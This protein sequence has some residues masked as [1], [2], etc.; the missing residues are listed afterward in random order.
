MDQRNNTPKQGAFNMTSSDQ[1]ICYHHSGFGG[2][3]HGFNRPYPGRLPLRNSS[4]SV[5]L[6]PLQLM[7]GFEQRSY[8]PA[9]QQTHGSGDT[10]VYHDR[11]FGGVRMTTPAPPSRRPSEMTGI[12]PT[13]AVESVDQICA[14]D[15]KIG[16]GPNV[17][18]PNLTREALDL[19]QRPY[20]RVAIDGL[21]NSDRFQNTF[22]SHF[23]AQNN[24][25]SYQPSIPPAI[26]DFQMRDSTLSPTLSTTTTNPSST[27]RD[28]SHPTFSAIEQRCFLLNTLYHICVDATAVYSRS[29]LPARHSRSR[30]RRYHPYR[31]TYP[32]HSSGN[33]AAGNASRNSA[34]PSLMDNISTICTHLWRKA[35][36][37][38]MAPHRAEADAVREMR[39]LYAWAE[40]VA[41][42]MDSDGLLSVDD[43]STDGGSVSEYGPGGGAGFNGS[44]GVEVPI[45]VGRAAKRICEWVGDEEGWDSCDS[46]CNEL[47]ELGEKD[48]DGDRRMN[49]DTRGR[50][51]EEVDDGEIV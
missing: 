8:S 12:Q 6:P 17:S 9:V 44:G 4:P 1:P 51:V 16:S 13:S 32:N 31:S 45:R 37:D 28:R 42:A 50:V 48:R 39:D 19:A 22:P 20:A 25:Q 11:G 21:L 24:T 5:T 26:P 14:C 10:I 38:V 18:I 40:L 35:R 33:G 3:R 34:Q 2:I 15:K 30:H 49:G 7:D 27:M 23:Q 47:R 36:H 41:R 43:I 46:V 29:L